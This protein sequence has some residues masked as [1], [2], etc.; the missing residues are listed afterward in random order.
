LESDR[1]DHEY[2]LAAGAIRAGPSRTILTFAICGVTFQRSN[3]SKPRAV[4]E[5]WHS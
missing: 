3:S 4:G 5:H 2:Q 1:I